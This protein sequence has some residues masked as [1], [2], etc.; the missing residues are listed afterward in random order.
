MI[1]REMR[2]PESRN[3]AEHG[4][5][6]RRKYRSRRWPVA[7]KDWC[8]HYHCKPPERLAD[9][10]CQLNSFDHYV[11]EQDGIRQNRHDAVEDPPDEDH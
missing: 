7:D 1:R 5:H 10:A 4:S 6:R 9:F 2:A 11:H 3:P 8:G